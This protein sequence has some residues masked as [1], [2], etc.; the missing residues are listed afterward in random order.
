M[1]KAIWGGTLMKTRV[2]CVDDQYGIRLLLK[3]ILKSDYDVMAVETGEEAIENMRVF[4][5]QVVILDMK[6]QKMKGTELLEAIRQIKCNIHTIMM[7]G[8]QDC[9]VLGEIKRYNPE[10]IIMKPFDVEQ[11]ISSVN[12]LINNNYKVLVS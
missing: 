2:L 10:K 12:E 4:D 6:L 11:I 7:T 1:I 9:D 5:P 3:E 8:Y